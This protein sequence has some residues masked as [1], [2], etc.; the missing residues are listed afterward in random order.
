MLPGVTPRPREVRA[1]SALS[2]AIAGVSAAAI[3]TLLGCLAHLDTA[4]AVIRPMSGAGPEAAEAIT[5]IRAD[6][7][8]QLIVAALTLLYFGLLGVLL[9]RPLRFVRPAVWV[10]AIL[11]FLGWACGL[12]QNTETQTERGSPAFP[13]LQ[14]AYHA[15]LPSWYSVANGFLVGSMFILLVALTIAV[16]RTGA[17][18]YYEFGPHDP[19]PGGYAYL[20]PDRA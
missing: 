8:F 16:L 7:R 4:G 6:L 13:E 17:A 5:S 12:A 14:A 19:P 1:A 3:A 18:E 11:L 2:F 15:L 20:R 10:G 9:L